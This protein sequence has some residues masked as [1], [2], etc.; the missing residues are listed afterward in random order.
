MKSRQDQGGCPFSSASSEA[1]EPRHGLQPG[2]ARTLDGLGGRR[3]SAWGSALRPGRRQPK[4][5]APGDDGTQDHQTFY[6]PHQSGVITPQP[7][8]ALIASFDVLAEDRAGLERLFRTLTERIAFLMKGGE[9]P[10]LD[11]TIP[12]ARFRPARAERVS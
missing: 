8:A 7:A 10:T 11:P 2:T 6:G 9:A 5:C 12:A 1:G 3:A 4:R